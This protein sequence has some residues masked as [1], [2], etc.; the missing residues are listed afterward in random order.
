V[1]KKAELDLLAGIADRYW[2][3]IRQVVQEAEK[4]TTKPKPVNAAL[5]RPT[6]RRPRS[7][8]VIVS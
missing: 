1:K 2:P 5:D 6:G 8:G 4:W 7:T 3:G